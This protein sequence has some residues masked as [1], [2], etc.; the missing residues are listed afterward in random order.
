MIAE[1]TQ[2]FLTLNYSFMGLQVAVESSTENS[3]SNN[4][5]FSK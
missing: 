3:S 4:L 5:I 2:A 1:P